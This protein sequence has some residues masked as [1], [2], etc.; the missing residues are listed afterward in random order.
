MPSPSSAAQIESARAWANKA[1]DLDKAL[2]KSPT[3]TEECDT[4]CAVTQ[5]NLGEFS[6]MEGDLLN[7]RK[8]YERGLSFSKSIGFEEG[9]MKGREAI[10]RLD[11]QKI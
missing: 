4:A 7:A 9:L 1:L 3:R 2:Q 5:I 6:E 8:C 10:M 11:K